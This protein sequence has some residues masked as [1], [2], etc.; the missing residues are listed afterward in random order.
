MVYVTPINQVS[1]P[2]KNV[3][4]PS[5]SAISDTHQ[6]YTNQT[7]RVEIRNIDHRF[8]Y[9]INIYRYHISIY[10][11]YI[12]IYIPYIYIY[13]PYICIIIYIPC[14]SHIPDLFRFNPSWPRC[15]SSLP[16]RWPSL[17]WPLHNGTSEAIWK[18]LQ[19]H[20]ISWGGHMVKP[21]LTWVS[22]I[23]AIENDQKPWFYHMIL[24]GRR[25]N[26]HYFSYRK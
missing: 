4:I 26:D 5:N 13:I 15:S 17:R 19:N 3:L 24:G 22:Y 12:Y 23:L 11:P 20:G 14:S 9:P 7:A 10:I 6:P 8:I 2:T 18:R 21:W 25:P 1:G 16:M